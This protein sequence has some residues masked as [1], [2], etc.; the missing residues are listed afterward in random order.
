MD[1]AVTQ[2]IAGMHFIRLVIGI[3]ERQITGSYLDFNK[4][5]RPIGCKLN[6]VQFS[7][8]YNIIF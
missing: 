5:E 1:V 3:L 2:C 6:A 8:S 4:I 7:H